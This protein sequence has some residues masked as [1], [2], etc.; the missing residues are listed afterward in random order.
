[1]LLALERC[2][3]I[4]HVSGTN[5]VDPFHLLAWCGGEGKITL[6]LSP[7]RSPAVLADEACLLMHQDRWASEP[8]RVG[9]V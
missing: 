3:W 5:L 9:E 2:P 8:C 6:S 4:F 1:M 7:F